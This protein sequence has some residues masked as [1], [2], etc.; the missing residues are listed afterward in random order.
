[1]LDFLRDGNKQPRSEASAILGAY[2]GVVQ[3]F[4]QVARLAGF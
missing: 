4:Q 1:V 2:P 3:V